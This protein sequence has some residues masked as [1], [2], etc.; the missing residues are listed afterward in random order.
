[1][2]VA[3]GALDG[4]CAVVSGAGTAFGAGTV[5]LALALSYWHR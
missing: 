2:P 1:M 5:V 3:A 4:A